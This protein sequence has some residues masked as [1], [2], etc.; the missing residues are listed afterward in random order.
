[1]T[2]NDRLE[3]TMSTWLR[4]DAPFRVADHLDEVLSVTA[5]TRQRP[6]WSSLERWLPVDTTFRP[7]FF[8]VPRAG[9]LVL[10]AALVIALLGVLVFAI[11]S[12]QQRLPAPFGP[13]R[14]GI[15]VTSRSGDLYTVDPSTSLSTPLV[16]GDGFDISPIFSRDGTRIAFLRSDGPLAEPAILTMMVTNADGTGLHAVTPPTQDLDWFDWSPNGRQVAYMAAGQL[17]VADASGGVPTMLPG[18]KPAHFPTWLPPDGKE[19]VFRQEAT[20]PAIMAI[21]PD[22][23]GMHALSTKRAE[24]KFDYQGPTVSP[25]GSLISFTR[26]SQ[27]GEPSGFLLDLRTSEERRLPAPDGTRADNGGLFAPDGRSI[28][29][30]RYYANATWQLI[31][32]PVDGSGVGT[33]IGPRSPGTPQSGNAGV[34]GLTFTPD[35]TALLVRYGDDTS[36]T[37][38]LLP[39]DGSEGRVI[40]AGEFQFVDVQ[41]LAP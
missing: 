9:R 31:L 32:A 14:N 1:M 21:R 12:R 13:A 39:I 15:F 3:R 20:D 33:P 7:R 17:W 34:N 10:V 29:F 4:E 28:A 6:A 18:T 41:R 22:G 16:L 24:N 8:N 11:G 30:V 5:E 37:T 2:S 35:G 38:R 19:I 23:T 27:F 26:Y 40:D 36:A 25:D